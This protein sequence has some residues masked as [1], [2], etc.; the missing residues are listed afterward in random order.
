ME[1]YT[2]PCRRE[3]QLFH[4]CSASVPGKLNI[5]KATRIC[6]GNLDRCSLS[7]ILATSLLDQMISV[8]LGI[9]A[10]YS[11]SSKPYLHSTAA[12]ASASPNRLAVLLPNERKAELCEQRLVAKQLTEGWFALETR[13][14]VSLTPA[15]TS[16]I[17]G[18]VD[19]IARTSHVE[20]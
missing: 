19:A 8:S 1:R 14:A 12:A 3:D 10:L 4:P 15:R 16:W 6:S 9:D 20:T 11:Q 7:V 18:G 13:C 17:G 5:F 2:V